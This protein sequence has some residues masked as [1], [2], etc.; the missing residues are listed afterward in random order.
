MPAECAKPFRTASKPLGGAR[1]YAKGLFRRIR[2]C[3]TTVKGRRS[4]V[5]QYSGR[6]PL[7]HLFGWMIRLS[8]TSVHRHGTLYDAPRRQF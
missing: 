4:F 2:V 1:D 5:Q 7:I 3:A 8:M 6:Q